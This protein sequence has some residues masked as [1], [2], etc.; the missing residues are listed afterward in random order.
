MK[1]AERRGKKIITFF[2]VAGIAAGSMA[3]LA[4]GDDD[5][6]NHV[7]SENSVTGGAEKQ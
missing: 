3:Y 7:D 2:A 5:Y 6:K 1:R 4:G